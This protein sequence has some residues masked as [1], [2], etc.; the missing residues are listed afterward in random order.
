MTDVC[1]GAGISP[2]DIRVSRQNRDLV[3]SH[4]NGQDSITLKSWF[5]NYT[6][7]VKQVEEIRFQ[8]GTVWS[9]DSLTVQGQTT[10]GDDGV[11]KLEGLSG[12]ANQLFGFGDADELY[13]GGYNDLLVGGTGN[14]YLGG[15]NGSDTFQYFR[16]D[17]YDTVQDPSGSDRILF[18]GF[19]LSEAQ[20]FRIGND[21]E[22]FFATGQGV[23]VTNHF[24][25]YIGGPQ[26]VE[27]LIF[28]DQQVS[29]S[30]FNGWANPKA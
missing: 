19:N 25:A 17:G 16:G 14:D 26:P 23:R 11:N 15:G 2:A 21:L 24:G 22:V 9:A 5:G 18:D 7:T 12:Y 10:L 3:L 4:V 27:F 30:Q 29:S 1:F 6:S 8:D 13:G 28:S 20:F